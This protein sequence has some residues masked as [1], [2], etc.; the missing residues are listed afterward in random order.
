MRIEH[1]AIWVKDIEGMK[2]FY[3]KYFA[4]SSNAKY[5]N[6]AKNFHSYF[7]QFQ[8]GCRLELMHKPALH[9]NS[10]P[11]AA[12]A[13]GIVHLAMSVG[14]KVLVDELVSQLAADGYQVVG[15]PRTT[16]DGYYE[17]VVLDPENNI[18]EITE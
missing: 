16:G 6:P 18:I 10:Q 5:H 1:V 17:G 2:A 12:P 14:S 8:D 7:L 3:E 13:Y 11:Y 9:E 4:A 15:Q